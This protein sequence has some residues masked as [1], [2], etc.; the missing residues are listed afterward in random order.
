[1]YVV[2]EGR[3]HVCMS[4]AV[5]FTL[6]VHTYTHVSPRGAKGCSVWVRVRIGTNYDR[7]QF[8]IHYDGA[9]VV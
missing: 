1:M 5:L 3:M 9:M 4:T 7:S 6:Y 8:K 2:K